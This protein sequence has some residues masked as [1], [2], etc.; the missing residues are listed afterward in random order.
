VVQPVLPLLEAQWD[1]LCDP[2]I[3]AVLSMLY[4]QTL[5]LQPRKAMWTGPKA[6]D[7]LDA[8]TRA[9]PGSPRVALASAISELHRPAAFGSSARCGVPQR[10][11]RAVAPRAAKSRRA[12]LAR[13]PP[14]APARRALQAC[15]RLSRRRCGVHDVDA[16]TFLP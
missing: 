9:A 1:Q 8:A 15:R 6:Q 16:G 7:V 2:E 14:H 5:R 11:V 4:G 3:G 13:E 10:S 12:L